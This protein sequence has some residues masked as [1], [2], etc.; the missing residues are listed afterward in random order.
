MIVARVL[1][2]ELP[3]LWDVFRPLLA[4]SFQF[5]THT[6]GVDDILEALISEEAQLWGVADE[7][8]VL[9]AVVTGIEAGPKAKVCN[10]LHLGGENVERWIGEMDAALT[11]FCK[12]NGCVSYEAITDR[13]GFS[14]LIPG[15]EVRGYL[16]VK[17]I[18]SEA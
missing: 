6:Y 9:G 13:K 3:Q 4:T 14:K 5:D 1:P 17:K 8:K 10:I 12:E 18:G 11:E 16:L 15:F 2:Y 7:G